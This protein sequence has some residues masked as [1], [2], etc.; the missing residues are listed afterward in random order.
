M[1][2]SGKL[3]GGVAGER[4]IVTL[5]RKKKFTNVVTQR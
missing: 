2:S 1:C 3:L 5:K 4:Q